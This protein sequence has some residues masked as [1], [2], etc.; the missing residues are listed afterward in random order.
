VLWL[1]PMSLV[2]HRTAFWLWTALSLV[3]LLLSAHIL[4][5]EFGDL[6][7]AVGIPFGLLV[8]A[9]F[10]VIMI[11]LQGQDSPILLL[12]VTLAFCSFERK[13]DAICGALLGL[14]L[15]KFQFILPLIAIL[16]FR[17][18]Y[19]LI[20]SF[21]FTS[22]ALLTV[23]IVMVGTSGLRLYWNLLA[24][25]TPEMVW[26]MP[27]LRGAVESL[28]G[29]PALT[30]VLSL[31]LVLGCGL[32]VSGM[33]A[34]EFPLATACALLVSYHGHVYDEVLLVIP[35]LWTLNRAIR[36]ED[37]IWEFWPALFFLIMP[38]YV[39]LTHY[40]ATWT[41]ALPI[42]PLAISIV[43]PFTSVSRG[44]RCVGE[45]LS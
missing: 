15:F 6:R 8:L 28:G 11:F 43:G 30:V 4:E 38:V 18:R 41:L 1:L 14:G 32:M 19:R 17:R 7:T 16:A 44:L 22:V 23:C 5:N 13:R 2:S 29:P 25:H 35:V 10:P 45:A 36:N 21:L 3:L 12:L 9:F 33:E 27:N 37:S 24:R 31:C 26:R 40:Q 42:L 39:L 34:G 20:G